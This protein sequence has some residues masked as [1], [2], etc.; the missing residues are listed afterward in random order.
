M[1]SEQTCEI[2][3]RHQSGSA[4]IGHFAVGVESKLLCYQRVQIRRGDQSGL[5]DVRDIP[6][7]VKC[8]LGRQCGY[9]FIR[10]LYG[11]GILDDLSIRVVGCI[12]SRSCVIERLY[13]FRHGRRG[14]VHSFCRFKHSGRSVFCG[15]IRL[16]DGFIRG[17]TVLRNQPVQLIFGVAHHKQDT[18]TEV[19]YIGRRSIAGRCPVGD[20][21]RRSGRLGGQASQR[22]IV[23]AHTAS[24][25]GGVHP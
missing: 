5:I 7:G 6:V 17:S 11:G 18:V 10:S 23:V 13:G 25:V 20:R 8:D 12:L 4:D 2:G 1:R 16:I 22:V 24:R 21:E 9:F 3:R 14:S 15:C 19:F